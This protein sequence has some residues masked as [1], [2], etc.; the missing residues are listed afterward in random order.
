MRCRYYHKSDLLADVAAGRKKL[1]RTS[2]MY[3]DQM[4]GDGNELLFSDHKEQEVRVC[5]CMHACAVVFMVGWRGC[6]AL[7]CT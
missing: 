5:V 6:F 2:K 7:A 4:W 3:L 1:D